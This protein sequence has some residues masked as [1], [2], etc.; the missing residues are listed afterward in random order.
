MSDLSGVVDKHLS[1]FTE[2]IEKIGGH[3]PEMW[4][5]MV[6]RQMVFSGMVSLAGIIGVFFFIDF[7]RAFFKKQGTAMKKPN[8]VGDGLDG[9]D[10]ADVKESFG[11]A[12]WIMVAICLGSAI[13]QIPNFFYPEAKLIMDILR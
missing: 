6:G 9:P 2:Q 3:A 4:E 7:S 5:A 10:D 12:A 13:M 11:I 8:Y 1:V